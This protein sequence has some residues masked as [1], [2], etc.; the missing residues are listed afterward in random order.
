ME[1]WF[2]WVGVPLLLVTFDLYHATNPGIQT[3]VNEVE[4]SGAIVGSFQLHGEEP[5]HVW[6]WC[7]GVVAPPIQEISFVIELGVW[8]NCTDVSRP[9]CAVLVFKFEE[10][11]K[12]LMKM[13]V[14]E[15]QDHVL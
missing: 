6:R 10:S 5:V 11:V 7:G 9:G 4:E 15:K 14:L 1:Q 12:F 2:V 3:L 13:G 8:W